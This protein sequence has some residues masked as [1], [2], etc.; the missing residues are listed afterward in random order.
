MQSLI[1]KDKKLSMEI[2]MKNIGKGK[3]VDKSNLQRFKTNN[4]NNNKLHNNYHREMFKELI[5]IMLGFK[6]IN[7]TLNNN[8]LIISKMNIFLNKIIVLSKLIR[9]K[10]LLKN[11]NFNIISNSKCN[12][13]DKMLTKE[14]QMVIIHGT[15]FNQI[16]LVTKIVQF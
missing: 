2:Y 4:Y 13:R 14:I 9:L 16:V 6:S 1:W 10:I 15:K 7:M 5:L 12:S 8:L 11:L 3:I